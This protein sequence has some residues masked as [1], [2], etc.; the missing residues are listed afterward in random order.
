M[1][2]AVKADTNNSSSS[3]VRKSRD[4][5]DDGNEDGDDVSSRLMRLAATAPLLTANLTTAI[6]ELYFNTGR[7]KSE[8]RTVQIKH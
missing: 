5:H 1:A 4:A 7:E 2:D 3:S 8:Y 6:A